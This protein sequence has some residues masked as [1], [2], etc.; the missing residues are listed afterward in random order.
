MNF[1]RRHRH[2]RVIAETH[3]RPFGPAQSASVD[4]DE[5]DYPELRFT[6]G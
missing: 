4:Y 3:L 2:I 5:I 6:I 1:F